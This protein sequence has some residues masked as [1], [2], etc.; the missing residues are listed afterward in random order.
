[1]RVVYSKDFLKTVAH[2]PISIQ[3]KLDELIALL[4]EEPF[5]PLL[6]SKR[7]KGKLKQFYSFRIT[8]EWR[9]IFS[10][11]GTDFIELVEVAHRKDIYR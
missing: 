2:L 3:E 7:L 9:V 4:A 8:R 11:E 5:H 10:F 6:H 1:M